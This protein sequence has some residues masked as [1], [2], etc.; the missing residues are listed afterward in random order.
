MPLKYRCPYCGYENVEHISWKATELKCRRCGRVIYPL[1]GIWR[2][3][4]GDR[5][6]FTL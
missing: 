5:S 4:K 6:L 1:A 3:R 2:A